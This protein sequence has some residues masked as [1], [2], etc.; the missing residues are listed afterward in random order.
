MKRLV[1]LNPASRNG[2]SARDF[3]ALLPALRHRWGNFKIHRTREPGDAS[4]TVR[5]AIRERAFD[6]IIAAG[7]D[8]TVHEIVNGY[9]DGD[10]IL[11][12]DIPLG[13]IDLGTGGDFFRTVSA[14]S[15]DYSRALDEGR[16]ASVDCGKVTRNLDGGPWHRFLNIASAGLGGLMLQ[17]LKRSRFQAG[18]AA[19]F[20]HSL[21]TLLRFTPGPVEIESISLDG[22]RESREVDLINFFVC[23]GRFSGG[24]M[25]WAP[26]ASLTSGCFNLTLI[27]GPRKLPL[28]LHAG[29]VYS[30]QISRFPGAQFWQSKEVVLRHRQ[31]L[32]V[33]VDGEI[34]A[35]AAGESLREIRFSLDERIF[36]LIH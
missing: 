11:T 18:A 9:F 6:I 26:G 35:E 27:R 1:V 30:G 32:S 2:K 34:I 19:Y 8:G 31:P 17:S 24:G 13:I 5:A 7:G 4:S 21:K 22:S 33:E 20:Y 15:D 10:Q 28:V 14:A 23:N 36:P 3:E 12:R 25:Q 16:F 29:K